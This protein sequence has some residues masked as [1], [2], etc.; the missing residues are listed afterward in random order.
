[1][2][3]FARDLLAELDAL[4]AE[5]AH[6]I[7][8]LPQ[9]AL[10]WSPGPE[11]NSLGVLATHIAGA[12]RY[13]LGDVIAGEPSNRDRPAEFQTSDIDAATLIARLADSLAYA[14]AVLGRLSLA[15]L[16]ATRIS[17]RDGR[18]FSVAWCLAHVLQ[19][20]AIHAGHIQITRQWWDH[21][22]G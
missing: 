6:A 1:M 4:H 17:P 19:H 5:I 12:E 7:E 20:T 3:P 9:T 8:G 10:D 16:E 21:Q 14:R 2:Q 15:D 11:I 18:T 22:R 13:W